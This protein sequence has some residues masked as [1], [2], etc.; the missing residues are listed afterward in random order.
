VE[1]DGSLDAAKAAFPAYYI[2]LDALRP[3]PAAN[4]HGLRRP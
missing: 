1:N 4:T 3:R 2:E